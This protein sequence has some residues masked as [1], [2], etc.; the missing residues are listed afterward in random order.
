MNPTHS[1]TAAKLRPALPTRCRPA[2]FRLN[3]SRPESRS[4]SPV[5]LA[6]GGV[7]TVY[8]LL[9]KLNRIKIG[10][11]HDK[12]KTQRLVGQFADIAATAP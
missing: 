4:R 5:T 11:F 10:V 3:A 12:A 6:T 7:A 1:T 8:T 2:A 9:L